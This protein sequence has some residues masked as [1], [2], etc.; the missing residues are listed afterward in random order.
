VFSTAPDSAAAEAYRY[1]RAHLDSLLARSEDGGK[2]VLVTGAQPREGRTCIASNLAAAMAQAGHR[3]LLVDA[4]LHHP[5]LAGVFQAGDRPGLTE[6]LAGRAALG[7]VAVSAGVPGLQLITV[8]EEDRPAELFD[9]ARLARVL[10][11]LRAAADVIIVDSGPVLSVSDPIALASVSDLVL[12]VANIRRS[13]RAA[14]RVAAQELRTA[15]TGTVVG[16]LAGLPRSLLR[17]RPRSALATGAQ[18]APRARA[19][20]PTPR[21]EPATG[22]SLIRPPDTSHHDHPDHDAAGNGRR[23]YPSPS[24]RAGSAA[25]AEQLRPP[26]HRLPASA[27]DNRL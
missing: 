20:P 23:R 9:A 16:V 25:V 26:P 1:L 10:K 11:R 18:P 12:M 17:S 8:G 2:V 13:R 4:D 3:V 7:D 24:H 22:I 19:L 14:I 27:D 21:T 5:S 15:D 6:L